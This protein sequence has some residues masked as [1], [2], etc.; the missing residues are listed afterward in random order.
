[1]KTL[2][3]FFILSFGLVSCSS[4]EET[5]IENSDFIGK[6]NWTNTDGGIGFHI[7]E[8]PE[9]TGKTYN[10]N[11]NANY[12]FS[13]FEDGTEIANGTYELTMKESIYSQDL[14]RFIT[15]SDNFQQTQNVVT[16]GVIRTSEDEN[17]DMSISDNLYDGVVSGFEKI[18]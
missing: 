15:Y 6:W 2:I 9:T 18:D 10:L 3:Y 1:M 16:S 5:K 8:T 7:H 14:E 13:F 12:S 11:L 17:Y 4:D